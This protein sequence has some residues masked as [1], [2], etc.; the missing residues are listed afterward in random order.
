MKNQLL[1]QGFRALLLALLISITPNATLLAQEAEAQEDTTAATTEEVTEEAPKATIEMKY[2]NEN[3]IRK[4]KLKATH[5]V[6]EEEVPL[7]FFVINVYLNEISKPGMMGNINTDENGEGEVMLNSKRFAAMA[8]KLSEYKFIASAGSDDR[9]GLT[10]AELTITEATLDLTLNAT[11]SGKYAF[12]KLYKMVNGEKEAVAEEEVM[13]FVKRSFN[14]LPVTGATDGE[15]ATPAMTD[16]NGEIAMLVPDDIP[17]DEAK[18]IVILAKV[19]EHGEFGTLVTEKTVKWGVP[20]VFNGKSEIRALWS[21]RD[22]APYWL[23]LTVTSIVAGVWLTICYII[24]QL[25]RIKNMG[26]NPSVQ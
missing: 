8:D 3:G 14:N 21:T 2:L 13:L 1:K 17:G 24:I 6:D 19:E 20:V 15:E 9:V 22:N 7:P 16:A 5:T 25:F 11:D 26:K 4:I 23:V 10:Q 12:I 18:N